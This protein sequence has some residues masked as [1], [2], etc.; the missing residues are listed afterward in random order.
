MIAEPT[1]REVLAEELLTRIEAALEEHRD[2]YEEQHHPRTQYLLRKLNPVDEMVELG[3]HRFMVTQVKKIRNKKGQ[4]AWER[5]EDRFLPYDLE[6]L[7]GVVGGRW[8]NGEE[9]PN[10]PVDRSV[11]LIRDQ[12]AIEG[13]LKNK[14][15]YDDDIRCEMLT[16]VKAKFEQQ[17]A[18][19]RA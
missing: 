13:R 18:R 10:M 1:T 4:Q 16:F 7:M 12:K 19:I 2:L 6:E 9:L 14:A 11:L 15:Y 5:P 8:V 17:L 3:D